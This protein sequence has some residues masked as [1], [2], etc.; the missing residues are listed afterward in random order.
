MTTTTQKI[1]LTINKLTKSQY[2]SVNNP[3]DSDLYFVIDENF[4]TS[5]QVDDLVNLANN[6]DNI[7]AGGSPQNLTN[8]SVE[9]ILDE[10]IEGA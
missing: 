2:Q 6:L 3:S 1:D 5:N 10:I 7:I 9:L 8:D 4:Y